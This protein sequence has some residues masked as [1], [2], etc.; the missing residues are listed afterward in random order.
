M[1]ARK[2]SRRRRRNPMG[3]QLEIIREGEDVVIRHHPPHGPGGKP[4]VRLNP[5]GRRV[6]TV[7]RYGSKLAKSRWPIWT[8][9][10]Y[11]ARARKDG[12]RTYRLVERFGPTRSGNKPSRKFVSDVREAAKAMG[13]PFVEGVRQGARA[14]PSKRNRRKNP[15]YRVTFATPVDSAAVRK[16]LKTAGFDKIRVRGGKKRKPGP[17]ALFVKAKMPSLMAQGMSASDAMKQVAVLWREKKARAGTR[18]NPSWKGK[19]RY[20]KRRRNPDARRVGTVTYPDA[21]AVW[22]LYWANVGDVW[23]GWAIPLRKRG[24]WMDDGHGHSYVG[25]TKASVEERVESFGGRVRWFSKSGR[26]S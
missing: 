5:K 24:Y 16:A 17:Y 10:I 8:G 7:A 22:D 13:L 14:N 18:A 12:V 3:G 23:P 21:G 2:R 25:P 15:N 26:R 4:H 1:A 9:A 20:S 11:E 19:R 6:V